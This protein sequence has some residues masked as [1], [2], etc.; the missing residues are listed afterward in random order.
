MS[1]EVTLHMLAVTIAYDEVD[2]MRHSARVAS[3]MP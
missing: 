3:G 1:G 2:T